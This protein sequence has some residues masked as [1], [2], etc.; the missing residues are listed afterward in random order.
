MPT[1]NMENT[2]NTNIISRKPKTHQNCIP[3]IFQQE[4]KG[5]KPAEYTQ[6][7]YTKYHI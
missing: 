2:Q 4:R 6:S 1:E 7:E 3:N 5:K